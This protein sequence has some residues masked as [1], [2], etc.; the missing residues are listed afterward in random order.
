MSIGIGTSGWS[1]EHWDG[2]LYP[3]GLLAARRLEVY[4]AR[5]DT[6]ELN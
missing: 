6:V 4:A 5:F 1:Y 2:V 3:A